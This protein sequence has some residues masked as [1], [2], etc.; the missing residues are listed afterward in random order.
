MRRRSLT[1]THLPCSLAFS[2]K[3]KNNRQV[4]N[5]YLSS[6]LSANTAQ[7][8]PPLWRN[9]DSCQAGLSIRH[10][11]SG[12]GYG[13]FI[14]TQAFTDYTVSQTARQLISLSVEEAS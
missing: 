12:R 4:E 14:N 7:F 5:Q 11:L 2:V 6:L 9:R 8:C 1:Y 13:C 3:N 10:L